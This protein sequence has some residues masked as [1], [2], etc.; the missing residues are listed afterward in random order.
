MEV[1]QPALREDFTTI[2]EV[3]QS[4]LDYSQQTE[5]PR[6]ATFG[7]AYIGGEH[8]FKRG[9]DVFTTALY[10][11]SL[12]DLIREDR[13][14][15][16]YLENLVGKDTVD[17]FLKAADALGA[18]MGERD[19]TT[20]SLEGDTAKVFS[21]AVKAFQEF[22]NRLLEKG[23]VSFTVSS[24]ITSRDYSKGSS[25]KVD[26]IAGIE[27]LTA[28]KT[29]TDYLHNLHKELSTL[30]SL[31]PTTAREIAER[32]GLRRALPSSTIPKKVQD[33]F[34]GETT[35]AFKPAGSHEVALE[36]VVKPKKGAERR[37]TLFLPP[38]TYERSGEELRKHRET[39]LSVANA[40]GAS[41]EGL[42]FQDLLSLIISGHHVWIP[43]GKG[44]EYILTIYDREGR[45]IS[46]KAW[47]ELYKESRVR[48]ATGATNRYATFHKLLWNAMERG[49]SLVITTPGGTITI[50]P[51][52]V[53]EMA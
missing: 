19:E 10:I 3:V 48:H 40:I 51:T 7:V 34:K 44:G 27:T 50:R 30:S 35:K 24:H 21:N 28:L 23:E 16:E 37:S 32:E 18:A 22:T 47:E 20:F 1:F 6:D 13:A 2:E 9:R 46:D 14:L 15:R 11:V 42:L 17:K 36:I 8:G 29:V 4:L 12:A 33:P 25:I 41:P 52:L 5:G 38:S 26:G 53:E 31:T 39:A 45:P 49:Y 43:Q